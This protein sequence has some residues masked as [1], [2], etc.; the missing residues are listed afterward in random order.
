MKAL[1]N[2]EPYAL[3]FITLLEEPVFKKY[4]DFK[5]MLAHF[6]NGG[7][8][9]CR[10]DDCKLFKACL[11]KQCSRDKKVDFCFQCPEFLCEITGFD[12]NLQKRWLTINKRMKEAGVEQYFEEIKD[13]SRY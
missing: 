9:G 13:K 4:P 8:K 10:S 5:E 2:F 6:T 12:E 3:R 1:G 11:V 7:C